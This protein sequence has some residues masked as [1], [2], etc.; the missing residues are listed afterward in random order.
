M[1]KRCWWNYYDERLS[2]LI[3]WFL[4]RDVLQFPFPLLIKGHCHG[5]FSA[6]LIKRDWNRGYLPLLIHEIHLEHQEKCWKKRGNCYSFLDIFSNQ[7]RRT[8]KCQPDCFKF[9]SLAR[10]GITMTWH[11]S[12]LHYTGVVIFTKIIS[13]FVGFRCPKCFFE[14]SNFWSHIRVSVWAVALLRLQP[15]SSIWSCAKVCRYIYLSRSQF[16]Y[17]VKSSLRQL[18]S[19]HTTLN[20]GSQD[21][22]FFLSFK[23]TIC[24]WIN[25][26]FGS[27]IV[28][29]LEVLRKNLSLFSVHIQSKIYKRDT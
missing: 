21:E 9:R 10:D 22:T 23:Q 27:Y 4:Y 13:L 29:R 3:I 16:P 8:W 15:Q 17:I 24:F 14:L 7:N 5:D 2:E 19:T 20:S 1:R 25:G 6:F 26:K 28:L 18:R 12:Q 11:F